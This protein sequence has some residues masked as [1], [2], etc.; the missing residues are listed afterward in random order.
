MISKFLISLNQ[1]IK[2]ELMQ[3]SMWFSKRKEILNNSIT[4]KSLNSLKKKENLIN[5]WKVKVQIGI[6]KDKR[7]MTKSELPI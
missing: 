5:S 2:S 1:K 7:S 3:G 6:R 4:K